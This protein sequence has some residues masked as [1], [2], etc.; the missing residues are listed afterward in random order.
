MG[1]P[2]RGRD[3]TAAGAGEPRWPA[4]LAIVVALGLYL[5]LPGTLTIGPRWVIPALEAALVVPLT[6]SAPY[7]RGEEARVVRFASIGLIALVILATVT[8]LALLVRAVL[9]GE[10]QNGRQLISSGVVIWLT[11]VIGFALWF[12]ELDRG[13]PTVRGHPDERDPDFLFPQMGTHELGQS[14]WMPAFLDYLY[15]SFTN[16]T[17]FSPTDTLPLTLRAKGL[18]LVESLASITTIVM[19]A[20]RAVNVLK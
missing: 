15:V 2:H 11:L 6:I 13:G 16:S 7:R 10:L 19:V 18:M 5:G 20:G 1:G 4:S 12:W 3:T 8:A 9:S 17:A 14:S